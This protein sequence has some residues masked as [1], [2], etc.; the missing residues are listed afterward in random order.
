MPGAAPSFSRADSALKW[1]AGHSLGDRALCWPL[2]PWAPAQPLVPLWAHLG[3]ESAVRSPFAWRPVLRDEWPEQ[4]CGCSAPPP[5]SGG[6]TPWPCAQV[7]PEGAAAGRCVRNAACS[8]DGRSAPARPGPEQ[9][10]CR[11]GWGPAC[12]PDL[13]QWP[14]LKTR[15][16]CESLPLCK[17]A[18][19]K[20]S[21]GGP[22]RGPFWLLCSFALKD[23]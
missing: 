12:G 5:G 4:R 7:S 11:E 1:G 23:V 21:P 22:F 9:R 14:W 20:Q 8:W 6:Q 19:A 17:G 13:G 10:P 3:S 2:C 18:R 15:N 16:E